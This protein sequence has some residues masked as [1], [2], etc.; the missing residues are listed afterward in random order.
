MQILHAKTHQESRDTLKFYRIAVFR[1]KNPL[2]EDVEENVPCK[3]ISTFLSPWFF[4]SDQN[5]AFGSNNHCCDFAHIQKIVA[6]NKERWSE[7]E[8]PSNATSADVIALERK[9]AD[10]LEEK[11]EAQ[12]NFTAAN[13]RE[14]LLKKRLAEIESHMAVLVELT[15]K[16]TTGIKP[17]DR[18]TK[19]TLKAK[20]LAIGKIYGITKVPSAYAEIFR[21]N[22]PKGLINW[23]GAPN[24]GSDDEKT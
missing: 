20:Y 9:I 2:G 21:K 4:R 19:D 8:A 15:N 16:V 10:L 7:S 3:L 22:M 24:Q 14:S 13:G 1:T 11:K 12:R 5:A 6:D 18:I 17:P 23:G